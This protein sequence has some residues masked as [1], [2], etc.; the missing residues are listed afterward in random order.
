MRGLT[1]ESAT[2]GGYR[3]DSFDQQRP[4][5]VYS[6]V[7]RILIGMIVTILRQSRRSSLNRLSER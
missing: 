7:W 5:A 4:E 2:D 3:A 1:V 6:G